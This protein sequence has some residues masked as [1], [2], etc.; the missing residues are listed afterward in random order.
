M[1]DII[2]DELS[3]GAIT[4]SFVDEAGAAVVPNWIKWT[5]TSADGLTII[6]EREQIDVPSPA[7]QIDILL[8]GADLQILETEAALKYAQR[9][10]T[11]EAEYDS[12]LGN[13]T[14]LKNEE[15]FRVK[16]LRYIK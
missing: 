13:N 14:P 1:A 12:D 4:C 2:F 7:E 9:L 16:N 6:N 5:L 8:S 10:L 3:S 11:V 15:R